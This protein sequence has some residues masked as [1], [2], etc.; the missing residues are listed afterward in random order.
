MISRYV[1]CAS[2]AFWKASKIF[3]KAT[4]LPDRLSVA[5]HTIP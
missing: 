4:T 3:F 1:R 2:V 5:F